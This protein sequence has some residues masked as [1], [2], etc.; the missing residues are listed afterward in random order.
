MAHISHSVVQEINVLDMSKGN[1][2]VTLTVKSNVVKVVVCYP[3]LHN[4]PTFEKFTFA[5]LY[6]LVADPSV[7]V[8]S[9]Q[10]IHQLY[11]MLAAFVVP[12]DTEIP[13]MLYSK[14]HLL[15]IMLLLLS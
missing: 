2:N 13:V 12:C 3:K 5:L 8:K 10:S 14:L 11:V 6:S 9:Q 4:T 15:I 7:F 1:A